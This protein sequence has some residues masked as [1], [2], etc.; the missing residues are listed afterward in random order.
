MTK[1]SRKNQTV[2]AFQSFLAA[3]E[4]KQKS[5]Y[6]RVERQMIGAVNNRGKNLTCDQVKDYCDRYLQVI[7]EGGSKIVY[8]M[9]DIVIA[10]HKA[11]SYYD[12]QIKRQVD[13]WNK[14]AL[15]N[16]AKYFNPILSYGLHRGDKID[17]TDYRYLNKSFI[18]SQKA[19]IFST[20]KQAIRRMYQLNNKAYTDSD[21]DEYYY[22]ME[23]AIWQAG[24]GDLKGENVG[25]IYDY[26]NDEY[27]T[28]FIDYGY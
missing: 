18:V 23:E 17:A 2:K 20:I 21:I 12:N 10:F 15:T 25:V 5:G 1:T 22:N 4:K 14:V 7:G 3:E 8:G 9:D 28:V 6:I 27:R 11:N 26:W 16:N 19:E 13:I 24:A